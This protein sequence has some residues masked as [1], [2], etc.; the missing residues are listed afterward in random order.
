MFIPY[1]VHRFC[2][3]RIPE[4]TTKKEW[5]NNLWS[6]SCLTF[7]SHSF[8]KIENFVPNFINRHRIRFE[9]IDNWVFLTQKLVNKISEKIVMGWIRDLSSGFRSKIRKPGF[10]RI[11]IKG[12]RKALDPGIIFT[13]F[14]PQR[15][16]SSD[17]MKKF[18]FWIRTLLQVG[19]IF[20]SKILCFAPQGGCTIWRNSSVVP[21]VS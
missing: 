1:P 7:L 17:R 20:I 21:C 8:N 2:S 5:K 18:R 12:S 19:V 9:L 4:P 14:I 16:S 6:G 10:P 3:S 15:L 11:R 13:F